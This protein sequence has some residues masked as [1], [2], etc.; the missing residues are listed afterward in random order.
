ML[1]A[2]CCGSGA[3]GW[4]VRM[5]VM[6]DDLGGRVDECFGW[7]RHRHVGV[8]VGGLRHETG[9]IRQKGP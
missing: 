8:L 4:V 2:E 7:H 9:G 1:D 6:G 3:K 5:G